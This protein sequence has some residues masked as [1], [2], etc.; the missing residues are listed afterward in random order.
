M[1]NTLKIIAIGAVIAGLAGCASMTLISLDSAEGPS[2]VRQGEDIDPKFVTVWGVYK[3][4]SRKLVTVNATNIVFNKHAPG[5]QTVR[6]R[7]RNQEATF[8]TEVMALRSLVIASPPRSTLFKAGQE[9]DR[10]W[11]GLEVRGEWD[12]MGSDRISLAVCEITGFLKDQVGKQTIRVSYEGRAATFDVEVRAMTNIQIAQA[13][14]KVDYAQG[15]SLDLTGLRVNGIWE[16]LP[17]EEIAVSANDVTGFNSN[18]TGI[19]RLTVTKSGRSATFNVEV[20]TLTGIVLDK[21]P[22]KTDYKLGE[23]LE[24]EGII[25]N[26]NYVG[27]VS[28]KKMTQPIPENQFNVSGFDSNRIG[29]QQRVT[30][31]VRGQIANFFVNIDLPDAS[32]GTSAQHALVGTWAI[33][34][35]TTVSLIYTFNSNGTGYLNTAS[36]T[37]KWTTSGNRVTIVNDSTG[38][39]GAMTY[40]VNG[41]TLTMTSDDN[42][43]MTFARR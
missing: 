26:G 18:N 23:P 28:T 38:V 41:N 19:Q 39:T 14:T 3:D 9:P 15:E 10:T 20:M 25:V 34:G 40:N 24:L 22:D 4:E 27:T 43:V 17:Q 5:P 31:T 7:I 11:P 30:I 13:P 2:Q 21:P 16:G 8:Q 29:R 32:S 6:I 33:T 12:Q 37:Y 1:K 35:N 42:Y 36:N